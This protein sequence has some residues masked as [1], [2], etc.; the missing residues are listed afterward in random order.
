MR[1]S[2][3]C[4]W[5]LILLAA[6]ALAGPKNEG[7]T[8]EVTLG[9][10]TVKRVTGFQVRYTFT[11]GIAQGPRPNE[12]DTALHFILHPKAEAA[13]PPKEEKLSLPFTALRQIK[14]TELKHYDKRHGYGKNLCG[15]DV[16][17]RFVWH[18]LLRDGR[19]I[20]ISDYC[21]AEFAES[22]ETLRLTRLQGR[23]GLEG[24]RIAI[25]QVPITWSDQGKLTRRMEWVKL[26]YFQSNEISY[27]S[28]RDD[29]EVRFID[30]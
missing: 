24:Y 29:L 26:N 16:G 8:A 14:I 21:F 4:L 9:D 19:K 17:G 12:T 5:L 22:G 27:I 2:A 18:F 6:V 28:W 11:A 30:P 20:V 25:R 7:V 13:T 23:G 15:S 10:G 3:R 1:T